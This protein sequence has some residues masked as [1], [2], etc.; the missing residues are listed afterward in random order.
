MSF[1]NWAMH[2]A[3][4]RPGVRYVDGRPDF[5]NEGWIPDWKRRFLKGLEIAF[6]I[7]V[8]QETYDTEGYPLASVYWA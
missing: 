4:C 3:G 1:L 5:E 2:D 8:N 7:S 6:N